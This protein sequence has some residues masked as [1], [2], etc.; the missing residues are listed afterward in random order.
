MDV[1]R[2]TGLKVEAIVGVHAWER[3]LPRVVVLD[4]QLGADA[5]AAACADRLADTLDY[6]AVA[7]AAAKFVQ[8]SRLQLIETLAE[9][10]AAALMQQFA[11]GWIAVTVHKPGAVPG[12][13]GV[14][15]SIER[16]RRT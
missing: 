15:I 11:V 2:I 14:S 9:R 3:K 10:L 7:Q 8:E 13:Q 5:A 4:L 6:H 1:I 12:A 16:G